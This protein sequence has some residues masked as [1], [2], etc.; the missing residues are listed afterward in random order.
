MK[1]EE[2]LMKKLEEELIT[3]DID[4]EKEEENQTME[5]KPN[6]VSLNIWHLTPLA[7]GHLHLNK[8]GFHLLE[9]RDF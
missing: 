2:E 9:K 8:L 1:E 6:I 5:N 3:Q 4:D 7:G